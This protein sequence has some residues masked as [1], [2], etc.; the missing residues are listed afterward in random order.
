MRPTWE[1]SVLRITRGNRVLSTAAVSV[2]AVL[3]LS[4]CNGSDET[5]AVDQLTPVAAI[6]KVADTASNDSATYTFEMSGKGVS[7][8]GSGAYRGGENPAARMAFDSM[9]MAG[10]SMPAGTEFRLVDDVLY[11]KSSKSGVIPGVGDGSWV[12]LPM[13]DAKSEGNSIG[14]LDL[15]MSNPADELKKMLDTQDVTRVGT[16]TIDGA[17]TTHY[18][19]NV[20]STGSGTVVEKKSS[21]NQNELSRQLE[22]QLSNSIKDSMGLSKPVTVDAW[23]DGDYH[24]RKLQVTLPFLGD[25]TMTMR[26]ADFGEDVNVEVPAG[27]KEM[28]FSDMLDGQ[29]GDAFG[30]EFR[31][32]FGQDFGQDFSKDFAD[33]FGTDGSTGSSDEFQ[34]KLREQIEKSLKDH[35][36]DSGGVSS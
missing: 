19:A 15:T 28:D 33:M 30:K 22:E 1:F 26:F 20:D 10:F 31:D 5:E 17:K 11:L 35:G 24:A 8:K 18:R 34:Q 9:K 36:V 25:M 14:G 13:D 27:A 12:K 2:A 6:Q 16:E 21:S 4:G 7:V 29:L 32:Q 3:T 23:V